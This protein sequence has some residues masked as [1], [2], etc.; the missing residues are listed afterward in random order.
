MGGKKS[1]KLRQHQGANQEPA[2][3]TEAN[4]ARGAVRVL[5]M[6]HGQSEANATKEDIL[7]P[8]LTPLGRMQVRRDM[9]VSHP[10]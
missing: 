8:P 6:R 9:G 7:D 10:R 5:L 1:K 2:E 3:C 4:L